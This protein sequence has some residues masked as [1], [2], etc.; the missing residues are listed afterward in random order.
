MCDIDQS[1]AR[2]AK[3]RRKIKQNT[4]AERRQSI[5]GYGGLKIKERRGLALSLALD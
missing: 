1:V 2:V 4:N 3:R 5:I